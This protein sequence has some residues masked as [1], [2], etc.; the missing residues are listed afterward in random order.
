MKRTSF[1]VQIQ[2]SAA[3]V[4]HALWTDDHYRNW[5]S[6][7]CEGSYAETDGWKT[8]TKVLFLSPGGGGLVSM[9][10]ENRPAQHMSFRHLGIVKDGVE[11]TASEA[12][13][14]WAGAEENYTLTEENGLTTVV[15]DMDISETEMEY[16]TK[17]WPLALARLKTL[18]ETAG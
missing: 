14:A 10:A 18:A 12:V 2:A 11:D 6:A 13:Q 4:W 15:V 7:F 5:T 16:F 9:V 17:T 8:G 3:Q 1:S